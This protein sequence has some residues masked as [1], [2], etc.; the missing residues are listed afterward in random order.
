M[1]CVSRL[2][3]C[4]VF[5]TI[6]AAAL[7]IVGAC[8]S[9]PAGE[10]SDAAIASGSDS[11]AGVAEAGHAVDGAQAT[12]PL[13]IRFPPVGSLTEA[14]SITVRGVASG[15]PTQIEIAVNGVAAEVE[16]VKPA[17]DTTPAQLR[18]RAIVPLESGVNRLH[19][20]AQMPN[21]PP[22]EAV[23]ELRNEI[24]WRSLL[25]MVFDA[26]GDTLYLLDSN[27]GVLAMNPETGATKILS[28]ADRVPRFSGHC[29]MAL[30]RRRSQLLVLTNAAGSVSPSSSHLVVIDL[31]NGSRWFMRR[32]GITLDNAIGMTIDYIND[33]A[34]VLT[35]GVQ[36]SG[37]G[38]TLEL[39]DPRCLPASVIAVDLETRERKR[40]ALKLDGPGFG[41][42]VMAVDAPGERLLNIQS[43]YDARTGTRNRVLAALDL[44]T[45]AR[46]TLATGTSSARS[47]V[48]TSGSAALDEGGQRVLFAEND[49]LWWVDLSR[50]SRTA[51]QYSPP[52]AMDRPL[53]RGVAIDSKRKRVYVADQ[54]R[55]R[56]RVVGFDGKTVASWGATRAAGPV[57]SGN[58]FKSRFEAQISGDDLLV[59]NSGAHRDHQLYRVDTRSGKRTLITT[60]DDVPLSHQS[61][62]SAF[63]TLGTTSGQA[64]V[65]ISERLLRVDLATGKHETLSAADVGSGPALTQPISV[66]GHA[67]NNRAY[68]L[69]SGTDPSGQTRATFRELIAVDLSNGERTTVVPPQ[70]AGEGPF[71]TLGSLVLDPAGE[72]LLFY[73]NAV[74]ALDL[75]S[76]SVS[77]LLPLQRAGGPCTSSRTV[78]PITP[79][80]WDPTASRLYLVIK[81]A[82][83]AFDLTGPVERNIITD[84]TQGTVGTGISGGLLPQG[85]AFDP[86]G[87]LLY[88][89]VPA[90]SAVMAIDPTS[91][92]RVIISR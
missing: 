65:V 58:S 89:V 11:G 88:A 69:Q 57:L 21:A 54:A 12:P 42:A 79:A 29:Y 35:K 62:P 24:I 48:D 40:L 31:K 60:L 8:D 1:Q 27:R 37:C 75:A 5:V 64:L 49:H 90:L 4:C 14:E 72:R 41:G 25:S 92:D 82:I 68:V 36:F 7:S 77:E 63:S 71:A 19:A 13:A 28:P 84:S 78:C 91:G 6:S 20:V 74:T 44:K 56:I 45:G 66:V 59:A 50:N 61:R 53:L 76:G 83:E 73:S 9:A 10:N 70:P 87:R 47:S 30:D 46:T 86:K 81:G 51:L 26:E 2:I 52:I 33:R 80:A 23:A 3:Q 85:I 32:D 18:W 22:V 39:S 43:H 17:S 38:T 67:A 15:D 34:L 16:V 55:Q